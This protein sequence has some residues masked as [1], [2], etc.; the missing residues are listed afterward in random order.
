MTI[1]RLQDI[2]RWDSFYSDDEIE[3]STF[4]CVYAPFKVI[5]FIEIFA[6]CPGFEE[7]SIQLEWPLQYGGQ[8]SEKP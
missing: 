8:Q 2:L 5:S 4:D 7:V 6:E 3:D 1:K